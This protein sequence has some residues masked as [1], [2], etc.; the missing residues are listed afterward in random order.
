MQ[1]RLTI[2][3][4]LVHATGILGDYASKQVELVEMRCGA[5]IRNRARGNQSL[6]GSTGGGVQR[7]KSSR[8]LI[9]ARIWI[10]ADV[11]QHVDHR[12]IAGEGDDG[13]CVE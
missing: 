6:S 2:S 12:R 4:A 3:A 7:V 5:R 1:R 11:E 13:G 10:G 9:A 8:P